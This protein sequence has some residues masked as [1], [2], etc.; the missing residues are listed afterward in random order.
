MLGKPN[1]P[2]APLQGDDPT[3]KLKN[4]KQVPVTV[5]TYVYETVKINFLDG[6]AGH[7]WIT[8]NDTYK[9]PAD[10]VK[11][12]TTYG[13]PVIDTPARVTPFSVAWENTLP[14]IYKIQFSKSGDRVTDI[15]VIF[16]GAEDIM[17]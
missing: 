11:L 6:K 1:E 15:G 10:T 8:L 14:D 5:G 3:F 2:I 4:G 9:Y 12:L 13:I 16:L 17:Q 7:V